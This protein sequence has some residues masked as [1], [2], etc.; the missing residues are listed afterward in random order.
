[1]LKSSPDALLCDPGQ[2]SMQGPQMLNFTRFT[3]NPLLPRK[4]TNSQI[5]KYKDHTRPALNSSPDNNIQAENPDRTRNFSTI[6]P[7]SPNLM[8]SKINA[9]PHLHLRD[10]CINLQS[11]TNL[12]RNLRYQRPASIP[13][14]RAGVPLIV[15]IIGILFVGVGVL[16][17]PSTPA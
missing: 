1:M 8:I 12:L 10:F 11:M 13:V 7:Q 14:F 17:V 9:K 15:I 5:F 16:Q 3:H 6:P 4:T 2:N